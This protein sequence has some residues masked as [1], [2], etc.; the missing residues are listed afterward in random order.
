MSTTFPA[1]AGWPASP[2]RSTAPAAPLALALV[3]VIGIACTDRSPQP[4]PSPD[5]PPRQI[6]MLML[7]AARPDRFSSYGYHRVTTPNLDALAE[8]SAVFTRHFAQATFTRIALPPMIYSR[9]FITPFR[10][11]H[12]DVPRVYPEDLFL[13]PDEQSISLPRAL[14]AAGFI[15]HAISA[16]T[17][18]SNGTGFAREFDALQDLTLGLNTPGR[19]YPEAAVVIDEAIDWLERRRWQDFFLYIHL[20]DT[21]A[22][23]YFEEDARHFFGASSHDTRRFR[24]D[25]T[26]ED[27]SH[28]LAPGDRAYLDALYDGSLRYTDRHVG[29]L[30]GYLEKR[31]RLEDTLIV[32]TG[33]HGEHLL[34]TPGRFAHAGPWFD[35]VAHIPLILFHP[36]RIEPRR[37]S[38]LTESIDVMPT[39]LPLLDVPLP[40]GKTVDGVDLLRAR[41]QGNGG[42]KEFVFARQ[43]IRSERYKCLFD[44]GDDVLLAEDPPVLEELSGALYDLAED[45]EER[46]NLWAARPEVAQELLEAYR[47]RQ[48]QAWRRYARSTTST[49]PGG[50]VAIRAYSWLTDP[51]VPEVE[52][53]PG[54]EAPD[55]VRMRS[56]LLARGGGGSI[57]IEFPLPD[58]EYAVTAELKGR[59]RVRLADRPAV[60]VTQP[61]G[62]A[63]L[64]IG[65]VTVDRERFR[66]TL[67]PGAEAGP[68][69]GWHIINFL[70]FEPLGSH[71]APLEEERRKRLQALGYLN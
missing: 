5:R 10:F 42:G 22:P 57:R 56:S 62:F 68:M 38:E 14:S 9:Y 70:L 49:Q 61:K 8:R 28:P 66:A 44:D 64:E 4:G 47:Q 20:M 31:G 58:G 1:R 36:P 26:V 34:E 55:H 13:V 48:T 6:I 27:T 21:H 2:S 7:D 45:P 43:G 11:M 41:D 46:T 71:L 23:H 54:P 39:L 60:E 24:A 32:V 40:A 63:R 50:A 67:T 25:G 65:R 59:F 53:V 51:E 52:A 30:L 33:D 37:Y 19:P 12:G 29:R 3:A 35:R 17:G 16:H 18:I 15:T 69:D